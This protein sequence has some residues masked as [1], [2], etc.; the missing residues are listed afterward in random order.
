[1]IERQ[2]AH[3]LVL[4]WIVLQQAFEKRHPPACRSASIVWQITSRLLGAQYS[5]NLALLYEA[6]NNPE[7]FT[8]SSYA[9]HIRKNALGKKLPETASSATILASCYFKSG[10]YFDAEKYFNIALNAQRALPSSPGLARTVY[11]LAQL[12]AGQGKYAEAEP[13]F[14]KALA[15]QEKAIP[16]HPDFANTLDAYSELLDRTD[17][18][19]AGEETRHR[20]DRIRQTHDK[21]NP[22]N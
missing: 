18:K 15:I 16:E 5:D 4:K 9:Y 6:Q 21:K 14:K 12:Y 17:R 2:A 11:G 8:V 7:A 20:A 19:T 13:L 1:M 10:N 22:D 3:S